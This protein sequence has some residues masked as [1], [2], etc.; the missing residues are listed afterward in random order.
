MLMGRIPVRSKVKGIRR[1]FTDDE[2]SS[3][4]VVNKSG[5]DEDLKDLVQKISLESVS[6]E[7]RREEARKPLYL[8]RYE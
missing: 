3:E 8:V 1:P 5:E 2:L 7:E 4:F 6:L